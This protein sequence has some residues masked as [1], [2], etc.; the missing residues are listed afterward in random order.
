MGP[1]G[2]G[3]I[4]EHSVGALQWTFPLVE[5]GSSTPLTHE[6]WSHTFSFVSSGE[7]RTWCGGLLPLHQHRVKAVHSTI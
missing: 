4:D 2:Y 3:A 5:A 6:R 1:A 7:R